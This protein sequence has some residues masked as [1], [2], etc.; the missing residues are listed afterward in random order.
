MYTA[1]PRSVAAYMT[2]CNGRLSA[3]DALQHSLVN[4]VVPA[5]QLIATAE[6]LADMIAQSSPLAVQAAVRLY[7]LAATFPPS[8]SAFARHLDQEIAETEDGAEG[9]KAFREKRRPVWKMR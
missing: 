9:A 8:L 6:G 1:M 4:K 3:Q 5:D 2:L 7:R